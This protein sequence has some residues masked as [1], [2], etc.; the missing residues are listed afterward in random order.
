MQDDVIV[1]DL[2]GEHIRALEQVADRRF[3]RLEEPL[4]PGPEWDIGNERVLAPVAYAAMYPAPIADGVTI[5]FDRVPHGRC[6][7]DLSSPVITSDGHR[8]G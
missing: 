3:V 7:V 5:L 8:V 4:D 2:D 1:V 6:E